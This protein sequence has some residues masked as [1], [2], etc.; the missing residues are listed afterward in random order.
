[1][2]ITAIICTHQPRQAVLAETLAHLQRQ[3]LPVAEWELILVDNASNPAVGPTGLCSWHPHGRI[4]VEPELGLTNA[5]LK[6]IAESRGELLVFVDDDNWLDPDYLAQALKLHAGTS[7]SLGAFGGQNIGKFECPPEPWHASYFWLLAIR[8]F[9][10][11]KWSREMSSGEVVPAGAGLCVRRDVAQHYREICAKRADV[12]IL[13]RKGTAVLLQHGDIHLVK[14]A[15][16]LGYSVGNF[17]QLRLQ[18]FMPASRLELSYLTRLWAGTVTSNFLLSYF[19]SGKVDWP[20]RDVR[21]WWRQVRGRLRNFH[22]HREFLKAEIEG[23][24]AAR[25]LIAELSRSQLPP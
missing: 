8:E 5:R 12:R 25:K 24:R 19:F 16:D 15:V 7:P 4:V 6:G 14:S 1:M 22:H 10:E 23:E 3:T 18:H 20:R 13:D 17:P 2:K 21:W 9:S 11:P